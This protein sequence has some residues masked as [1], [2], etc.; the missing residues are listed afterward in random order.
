MLIAY[1]VGAACAESKNSEGSIVKGV[2][3][4]NCYQQETLF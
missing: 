3:N 1:L 2:Y 4:I